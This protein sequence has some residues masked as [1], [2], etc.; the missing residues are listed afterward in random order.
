M[1]FVNFVVRLRAGS[2]SSERVLVVALD[3]LPLPSV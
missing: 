1:A 2:P 3:Y